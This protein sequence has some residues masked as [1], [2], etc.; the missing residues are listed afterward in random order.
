MRVAPPP[1]CYTRQTGPAPL[2]Q[3]ARR[4]VPSAMDRLGRGLRLAPFA[5]ARSGAARAAALRA[6]RRAGRRGRRPCA[7]LHVAVELG[8]LFDHERRGVDVARHVRRLVQHD[9]I[10]GVDVA[11]DHTADHDADRLDRGVD[12]SR[13]ADDQGVVAGDLAAEGAVDADRILERELALELGALIDEGREVA[14]GG[15]STA[16][17]A[18]AGHRG[19]RPHRLRPTLASPT[20]S[21]DCHAICAPP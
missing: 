2:A 1:A 20:E 9:L 19:R 11:L 10:A 3:L 6:R 18:A 5:V 17:R 13:L 12:L 21:A 15:A 8:A 14:E 7:H 4:L 16:A